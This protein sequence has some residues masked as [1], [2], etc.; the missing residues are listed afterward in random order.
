MLSLSGVTV[1]A[2]FMKIL[3]GSRNYWSQ[4][5][6]TDRSLQKCAYQVLIKILASF[7]FL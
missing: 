2:Y 3:S 6:T 5:R 4:L 7:N 1:V